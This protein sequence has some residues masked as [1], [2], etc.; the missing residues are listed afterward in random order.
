[1]R[2]RPDSIKAEVAL[3]QGPAA[4]FKKGDSGEMCQSADPQAISAARLKHRGKQRGALRL[5]CGSFNP[6]LLLL[7]LAQTSLDQE[8]KRD[9]PAPWTALELKRQ[10]GEERSRL[11]SPYAPHTCTLLPNACIHVRGTLTAILVAFF[12]LATHESVA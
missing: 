8:K 10:S 9:N 5:I 1:M 7:L 4:S 12:F 6:Q 11:T 2:R 3:S